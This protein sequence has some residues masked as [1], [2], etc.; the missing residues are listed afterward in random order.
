MLM[1]MHLEAE[2]LI[3]KNIMFSNV[4]QY[5]EVWDRR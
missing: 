3:M 4:T 2:N 1:M 5:R